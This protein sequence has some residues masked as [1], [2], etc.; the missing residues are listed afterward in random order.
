MVT[1]ILPGAQD[2][3]L[4]LDRD[5]RERTQV[6]T[7]IL[8]KD[9]L[10][11]LAFAR[12]TA[13]LYLAFLEPNTQVVRIGGVLHTAILATSRGNQQQGALL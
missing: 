3:L 13:R 12:R 9:Q 6:G 8:L 11:C 10:V 1:L 4:G 7:S 2:P 5:Q